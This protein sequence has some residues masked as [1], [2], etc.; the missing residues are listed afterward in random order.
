MRIIPRSLKP[1]SNAL[2]WSIGNSNSYYDWSTINKNGVEFRLKTSAASGDSRAMY[3]RMK[4]AGAGG[5]EAGRFYSQVSSTGVAAGGTVNAI[6]AGTVIDAGA[7]IP[8]GNVNA[9]RATIEAASESR[10]LAG[11]GAA[12]LLDSNIGAS[13]TVPSTTNGW[14]F[15]R[16]ADL[17]SVVIPNLLS[18]PAASNGTIFAA[19]TTQIMTHSIRF[20]AGGT[21]YYVMCT[22]AATNRS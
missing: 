20:V 16:V 6:H 4:F 14:S 19:H 5:G 7:T 1:S 12:L 9:I 11:T 15:I 10:T 21:A 17:G 22:N 13:N 18:V 8:T 2:F 3:I